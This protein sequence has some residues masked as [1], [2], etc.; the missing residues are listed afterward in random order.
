MK[1]DDLVVVNLKNEHH[2]SEIIP[3]KEAGKT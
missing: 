1:N 2:I 3:G